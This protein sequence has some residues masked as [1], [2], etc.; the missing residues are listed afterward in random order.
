MQMQPTVLLQKVKNPLREMQKRKVYV[1]PNLTKIASPDTVK[2]TS[3]HGA[4]FNRQSK[5]PANPA[6][7]YNV[8]LE[9]KRRFTGGKT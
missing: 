8:S 3:H 4:H 6:W 7:E 2:Q 5:D 1:N 9:P